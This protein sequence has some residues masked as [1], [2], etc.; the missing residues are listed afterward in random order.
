MIGRIAGRLLAKQPPQIIVDV[1]GVGYELD[2]P[3][4]TLYQLPA[5]G[6]AVTHEPPPSS[7]VDPATLDRRV[8]QH[9]LLDGGCLVVVVRQ[10][11]RAVLETLV[12]HEALGSVK[13]VV[14]VSDDVDL[15]DTENLVYMSTL[16]VL[17]A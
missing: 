7:V 4:S 2:V 17:I 9:K 8:V 16:P 13:F 6:E 1:N 3:M 12:R 10:E 15:D 5:T 14:A 11:P